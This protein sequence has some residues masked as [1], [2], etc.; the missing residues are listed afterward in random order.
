MTC[1]EERGARSPEKRDAGRA[2]RGPDRSGPGSREADRGT[3]RLLRHHETRGSAARLR[4]AHEL[5]ATRA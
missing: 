3:E 5:H 1:F 2:K 4:N